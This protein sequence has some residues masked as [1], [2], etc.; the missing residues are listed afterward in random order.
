ML[1]DERLSKF[2]LY[3]DHLQVKYRFSLLQNR[4]DDKKKNAGCNDTNRLY[5]LTQKG[6]DSPENTSLGNAAFYQKANLPAAFT[7]T[8]CFSDKTVRFDNLISLH[9]C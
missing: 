6:L 7:L 1:P 3:L 5:R 8:P 4:N 2:H 9:Y